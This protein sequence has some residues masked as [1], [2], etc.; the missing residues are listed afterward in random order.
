MGNT[1]LLKLKFLSLENQ[2][3]VGIQK[4]A[5]PDFKCS[6]ISGFQMVSKFQMVDKMVA[7]LSGFRMVLYGLRLVDIMV[8][9]FPVFIWF[10]PGFECS[11]PVFFRISNGLTIQ[12]MTSKSLHF[13]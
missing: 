11:C 12:K 13:K 9:I 1:A 7:I 4:S 5:R 8:A 3:T 10:C 2:N 6:P